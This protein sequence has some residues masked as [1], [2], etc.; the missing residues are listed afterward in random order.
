MFTHLALG[1]GGIKGCVITGAL[2]ALNNIFDIN[3]IKYIIGSSAGGIVGTMLCIGFNPTELTEIFLK[4]N[5]A[6]YRDV[7]ISNM[8]STFGA[9][10]CTKLMRLLK[11]IIEQ[12]VKKDITFQELYIKTGKT[13]ILTG[14]NISDIKSVYFSRI[15]Y[16]N[17]KIIDA[18]RITLS[19]PILFEPV[20]LNGKYMIDGAALD[21]YPIEYFKGIKRK[22]GIVL[23]TK[24]T[25][26]V[27]HK[28]NN[29]ISYSGA[30]IF[31]IVKKFN[32]KLVRKNIKD[33]ILINLPDIH[34]LEFG[35][36]TDIK[37]NLRDIGY[38]TTLKYM[39]TRIKKFYH[40]SQLKKYFY[41]WKNLN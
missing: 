1:G 33:T 8:L 13:L 18:L 26:E 19:Y 34:A 9:D 11:A 16:P 36:S 29:F 10:D 6:E 12:K 24:K 20:K 27:E 3:R 2:E 4:I 15:T 37:Q 35:I 21:D 30:V 7:K 17:M 32:K 38:E 28:I 40:H 41:K 22:I 31:S 39:N 5:L 23:D 14:S 25:K